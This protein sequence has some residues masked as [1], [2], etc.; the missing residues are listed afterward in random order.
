[1]NTPLSPAL[2]SRLQ[3]WINTAVL[4]EEVANESGNLLYDI[5]QGAQDGRRQMGEN[6]D[7]EEDDHPLWC[8]N[9]QITGLLE[10]EGATEDHEAVLAFLRS[11]RLPERTVKRMHA[12]L[13]FG[14]TKI[15]HAQM[16]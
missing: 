13:C 10:G 5:Y 1:M 16:L 6:L 2:L 9:A 8:I 15:V 3:L 12:A 7:G 4:H 11:T 14:D